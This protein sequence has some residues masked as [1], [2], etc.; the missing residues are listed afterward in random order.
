MK[1]QRDIVLAALRRQKPES[2]NRIAYLLN[3]DVLSA[4]QVLEELEKQGYIQRTLESKWTLPQ[5]T[6]YFL[7]G[8]DDCCN[9]IKVVFASR[10]LLQIR[11]VSDDI[12]AEITLK[13]KSF[14]YHTHH[15]VAAEHVVPGRNILQIIPGPTAGVIDDD[16]QLDIIVNNQTE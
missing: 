13:K 15:G 9:Q 7:H 5:E 12:L 8:K 3:L 1:E 11:N 4:T 10:E 2:T 6:S 14:V 16:G